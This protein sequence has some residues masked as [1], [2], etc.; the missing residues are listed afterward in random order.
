M[1]WSTSSL[2]PAEGGSS[3][4]N[5]Q[6][7]KVPTKVLDDEEEQ[8]FEIEEVMDHKLGRGGLQ[9]YIKWKGFPTSANTWEPIENLN[10]PSILLRYL[11]KMPTLGK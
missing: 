3:E 11:R 2:S 1:E 7:S 4:D 10:C 8:T 9:F 6:Q 5:N